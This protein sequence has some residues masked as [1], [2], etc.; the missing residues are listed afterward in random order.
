MFPSLDLWR[1]SSLRIYILCPCAIPLVGCSSFRKLIRVELKSGSR[2]KS[3]FLHLPS[4]RPGLPRILWVFSLGEAS[5]SV[6]SSCP[7]L[8]LFLV[9]SFF[10]SI[11]SFS[12]CSIT[13]APF[14][15][16]AWVGRGCL[17]SLVCSGGFSSFRSHF[18]ITI[19]ASGPHPHSH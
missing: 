14:Y 8:F 10:F 1:P 6:I 15:F 18:R 4:D 19:L 16:Y 3:D 5:H 9:S 17:V 11:S 13:I 7:C 12:P 2:N